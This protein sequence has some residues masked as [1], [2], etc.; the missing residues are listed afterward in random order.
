MTS[1]DVTRQRLRSPRGAF[2]ALLCA[3]LSF[4]LLQ[5][6]VIPAL[7]E[8]RTEFHASPSTMSWVLSA[9]LLTS[10]VG[11]VLLGRLGDMFGKKRLMLVSLALLGLGT[12]VSALATTAGTLIAGRAVQG[13]GAA[14]F[15]LAFGL[16]RDM[17]DRDRVPV[18]IG[19]IS[20]AFGIGFGIGL[21]IAGPILDHLGWPWIFWISL[22]VVTI[23]FA[24]VAVSISETRTRRH[25]R[26]DWLGAILVTAGL[27][28]VLLAISQART[29]TL[30]GTAAL[31]VSGTM[32]L[33]VFA[34]VE[35]RVKEPLID[36]SMLGRRSVLGANLVA[37]LIGAGLYSAFSLVPQF[38]QTPADAG[39]GFGATPTRS[40]LF[41]L[42]MAVT[43]LI[44]GPVAGRLGARTGFKST[45]VAACVIS[46]A[47]F[48]VIAAGLDSA[49]AIATGAG[50]IGVGVGFAFSSVV[51]LVVSAVQPQ[52]T[53]VA[54][55]VNTIMRTIGGAL[56]AQA[57]PA[58]VTSALVAGTSVPAESGYAV[59]FVVSAAVMAAAALAALAV[60]G[61]RLA[62]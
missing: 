52:E 44:A 6:M 16:V 20:A 19:T 21:V 18:V 46:L 61:S 13:L 4:S 12:L 31:V 40:G 33:A 56:G 49:W 15:P 17:F 51:N 23:A 36:L 9:F 35:R 38:V 53:G 41:L 59:A 48:V 3:V 10:S 1:S 7:P 11:A 50:I 8:L 25:G 24:A 28:A 55:G 29:W 45:L 32:A 14:T 60:P 43:M 39:Y 37:L 57:G 54:T 27:T 30:P 22:I 34:V 58:I 26:I 47:G 62:A 2:A 5:T 42:P